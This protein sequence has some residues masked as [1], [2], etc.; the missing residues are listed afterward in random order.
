LKESGDPFVLL[1]CS[2]IGAQEIRTHFPNILAETAARGIDMLREP[3]PVV[4]AAHYVCGGVLTDTTGR[5]S[6]PG[7]YAIGEAACTGVHGA[8]RLASNSLLEAL[9]FAGRAADQ[10]GPQLAGW[11]R[12]PGEAGAPMVGSGR[13]VADVEPLRS[14]LRHLMWDLVGIVRA[15]GRLAE[16]AASLASMQTRFDRL[17]VQSTLTPELLELRNLIQCG[18]LIVTSALARRE[19]RGLN[20]NLDHPYRDNERFLSDTVISSWIDGAEA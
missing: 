8:N 11:P 4:P 16:A 9:V 7:L 17:A 5:S 18:A 10:I 20:F 13:T 6:L 3:L 15:D 14:E 1:D 19:S 2:P 12:L